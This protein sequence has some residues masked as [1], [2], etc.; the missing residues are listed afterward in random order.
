MGFRLS[1]I[2]DL[3][4]LQGYLLTSSSASVCGLFLLLPAG[5]LPA[6]SRGGQLSLLCR[7]CS[8]SAEALLSVTMGDRAAQLTR[9]APHSCLHGNSSLSP[10]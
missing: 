5:L 7:L 6:V 4:H 9:P 2:Q 3:R 1:W 10:S 8:C